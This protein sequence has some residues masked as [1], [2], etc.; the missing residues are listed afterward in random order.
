MFLALVLSMLAAAPLPGELACTPVPGDV[1]TRPIAALQG[2]HPAALDGAQ[3]V[4]TGSEVL[5]WTNWSDAP[6]QARTLEHADLLAYSPERD[7]WRPLRF[8]GLPHLRRPSFVWVAGR[9]VLWGGVDADASRATNVGAIIDPASGSVVRTSLQG[10]PL[11]R[12]YQVAAAVGGKLAIFGGGGIGGVNRWACDGALFDPIANAWSP[13]AAPPAELCPLVQNIRLGAGSSDRLALLVPLYDP[14]ST[15]RAAIYD[16]A[17]G[18]WTLGLPFVA[19]PGLRFE[20]APAFGPD[21]AAYA[22][23]SDGFADHPARLFRIDPGDGHFEELGTTCA[24][25]PMFRAGDRLRIAGPGVT[26]EID[27]ARRACTLPMRA[28]GYSSPGAQQVLVS[29]DELLIAWGFGRG[30][31]V[32]FGASPILIDQGANVR[33]AVIS[34][35]P[36]H[37]GGAMLPPWAVVGGVTPGKDLE[38]LVRRGTKNLEPRVVAR[39]RTDGDGLFTARLG[40]GTYCV[41]GLSQENVK[42]K[43]PKGTRKDVAQCLAEENAKCLATFTVKDRATPASVVVRI[44]HSCFG[45]C[46]R[47]PPPP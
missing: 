46:F 20:Y 1:T 37:C 36:G 24:A 4:W 19:G 25:G 45:P 11:G 2:L 27:V 22:L 6:A 9:A 10:A 30:S 31:V 21:G 34:D 41:V 26:C 15:V 8:P 47:G 42:P 33:G 14:A 12:Q 18:R 44:P 23:A 16:V 3:A 40:P 28:V 43:L 5:I 29:S 35:L 32:R 7:A 38:L 13:L 39:V 17:R